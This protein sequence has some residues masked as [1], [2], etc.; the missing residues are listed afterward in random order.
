MADLTGSVIAIIL[1][2]ALVLPIA[3]AIWA[4]FKGQRRVD[5]TKLSWPAKVRGYPQAYGS[6]P[7]PP[8]NCEISHKAY[9]GIDQV[10]SVSYAKILLIQ[11]RKVTNV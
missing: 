5:L 11:Q 10:M 8:E 3:I 1:I 7:Q 4:V 2:A 9:A 6:Y